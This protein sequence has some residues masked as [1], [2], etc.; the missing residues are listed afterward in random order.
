MTSTGDLT[1]PSKLSWLKVVITV[2]SADCVNAFLNAE[3]VSL[4][5]DGN[6]CDRHV[7][8]KGI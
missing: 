2:L 1:R 4:N 8:K 6:M 7:K 5:S 3:E